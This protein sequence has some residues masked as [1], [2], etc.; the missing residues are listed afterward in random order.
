MDSQIVE[1]FQKFYQKIE[2]T[3][4]HHASPQD[5]VSW[6]EDWYLDVIEENPYIPPLPKKLFEELAADIPYFVANP[7]L[8]S[9]ACSYYGEMELLHKLK[10][11][12]NQF[13]S[14]CSETKV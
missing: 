3:L 10:I 6:Y 1:L 14:L 5:F 12:K 2:E 9:E 7:A 8:R 4:Q 13:V 11:L